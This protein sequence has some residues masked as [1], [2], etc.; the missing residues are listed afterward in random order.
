MF[1]LNRL[2][3]SSLDFDMAVQSLECSNM[4]WDKTEDIQ[5]IDSMRKK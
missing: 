5:L 1:C 2:I 4:L 3:N